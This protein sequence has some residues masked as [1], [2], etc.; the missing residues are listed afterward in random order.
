MRF[1]IAP[2]RSRVEIHGSTNLHPVRAEADGPQGWIDAAIAEGRVDVSSQP[3][4]H[5]E[6]AVDRLR[7]GN[8]MFERE[9]QRRVDARRY[10]TIV[11]ELRMTR[12]TRT[13]GRYAVEGDLTFHGVTRTVGGEVTVA[14]LGDR[15]LRVEGE[16]V[17]DIRD[18]GLDPPKVLMLRAMPE[19]TARIAVEADP[20][21][22]GDGRTSGGR[23]RR[24]SDRRTGGTPCA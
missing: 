16:H 19:V 23:R 22:A 5:V 10:P 6:F 1:R 20:D 9:L 14:V 18:F 4:A 12:E 13:P 17:F 2:E 8:T 15:G 21:G 11:G 24:R 3:R 7:S